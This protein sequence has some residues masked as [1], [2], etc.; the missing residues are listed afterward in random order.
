MI[1][2]NLFPLDDKNCSR[3]INLYSSN[4]N[5]GCPYALHPDSDSKAIREGLI[6]RSFGNF[7]GSNATVLLA[8]FSAARMKSEDFR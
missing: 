2:K 4:P 8:V 5:A 7:S 6:V 3:V 1:L